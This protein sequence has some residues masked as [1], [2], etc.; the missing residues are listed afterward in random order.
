[1]KKVI[2]M[3]EKMNMGGVEKALISMLE[4]I[5]YDNYDVTLLLTAIEG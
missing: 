4:S 5:N 1:M 3:S 2:I